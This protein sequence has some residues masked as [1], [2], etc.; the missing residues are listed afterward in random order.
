MLLEPAWPLKVVLNSPA[1]PHNFGIEALIVEVMQS[2][3]RTILRSSCRWLCSRYAVGQQAK[4]GCH[5]RLK[6]VRYSSIVTAAQ[7][8]G[9]RVTGSAHSEAAGAAEP[10]EGA[11]PGWP[12]RIA[13]PRVCAP[14]VCLLRHSLPL[15]AGDEAS[16]TPYTILRSWIIF[17]YW[18]CQKS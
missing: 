18:S 5:E 2:D 8:R 15:A 9:V 16:Q 14:G 3:S 17:C 4:L 7:L 1:S 11:R 10:G 6:R 12:H 13:R